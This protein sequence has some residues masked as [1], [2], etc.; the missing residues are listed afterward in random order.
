MKKKLI[1]FVLIGALAL[2]F[3]C[4]SDDPVPLSEND[5][6]QTPKDRLTRPS[7]WAIRSILLGNTE[8]MEPCH[9]DDVMMFLKDNTCIISI[10]R[11]RCELED[12]DTNGTWNFHGANESLLTIVRNG[13]SDE[14]TILE[15]TQTLL[16]ITSPAQGPDEENYTLTFAAK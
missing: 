15:F 1:S 11:D 5:A 14:F 3:Q 16:K 6:S 4:T 2:S 8:M 12:A 13:M 10:G 9:N 7:G